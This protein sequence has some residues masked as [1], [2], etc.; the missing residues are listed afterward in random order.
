MNG[1]FTEHTFCF[2][3]TQF[4]IYI[5]QDQKFMDMICAAILFGK[6]A[7][8]A[9]PF[10]LTKPSAPTFFTG[11]KIQGFIRIFHNRSEEPVFDTVQLLLRGIWESYTIR[12]KQAND[13]IT[14]SVNNVVRQ[15]AG[16]CWR[17]TKPVSRF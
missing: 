13:S 1:R 15:Q 5:R 4:N 3:K 16:I 17:I 12:N 10:V 6:E 11:Q 8:S 14:G 9:A 2:S 7:E